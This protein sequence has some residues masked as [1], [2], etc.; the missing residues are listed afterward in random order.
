MISLTI[1][2]YSTALFSTWYFIEELGILFDAGDGLTAALMQKAR[3]VNHVFISHADRDHL[4]GLLQFN[5]L[6]ARAGYPVIYFP[7][8][9]N[10]FPALA[11][12]S[13]KFD[14]HVGSISW[15]PVGEDDEIH[16]RDDIVIVPV[17]NGHVPA[18][19]NISKS[20]GYKIVQIRRK[21]KPE[22]AGLTGEEI[23]HI[24][25][26]KGKDATTY[27]VRTTLL[28]YS[29]DTPVEDPLR[30][31]ES[32][33]LIHEAT[34]MTGDKEPVIST[35]RNKHSTLEEVMEMVSGIH[36]E[37]LILGHFSTRYAPEEIDKR[38]RELSKKYHLSIPVFRL[39]PGETVFDILNKSPVNL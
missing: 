1:S 27:E 38:I 4:A 35:N 7:R 6:N 5:Q 33:I 39:L 19:E 14:P 15:V 30:W 22:L 37:K 29:G 13:R 32:G 9:S 20:L 3:K 12:F 23:R 34:F 16:L 28:G 8:N 10:S 11:S 2:G 21:L 25:E 26:T 18:S 31:N 17:R 24:S 36:I